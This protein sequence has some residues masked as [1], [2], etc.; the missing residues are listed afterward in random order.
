MSEGLEQVRSLTDQKY[1]YGFVT[2]IEAESAPKGLSE[3]TIH[4]ISAKKGEPDWLLE[5]RLK[6]YRRWLSERE[7]TWA[8]VHHPPIDYQDAFY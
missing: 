7:P 6:A 4:F 2:D 8:K 5:W 1:R 3:A